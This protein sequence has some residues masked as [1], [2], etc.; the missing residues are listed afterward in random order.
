[1]TRLIYSELDRDTGNVLH[2][3][4]TGVRGQFVEVQINDETVKLLTRDMLDALHGLSGL[5]MPCGQH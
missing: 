3:K 2:L 5:E 1:M 4:Q